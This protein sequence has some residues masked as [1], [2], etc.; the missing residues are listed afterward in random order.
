MAETF[1]KTKF[2]LVLF[3]WINQDRSYLGGPIQQARSNSEDLCVTYSVGEERRIELREVSIAHSIYMPRSTDPS[4]NTFQRVRSYT[5]IPATSSQL[6][7][8]FSCDVTTEKSMDSCF[9]FLLLLSRS[10]MFFSP[11]LFCSVLRRLSLFLSHLTS[12]SD[13]FRSLVCFAEQHRWKA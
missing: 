6:C 7:H 13:L 4:L 12:R 1:L 9:P 5:V 10:V 2:K 3:T 8:A 11:V